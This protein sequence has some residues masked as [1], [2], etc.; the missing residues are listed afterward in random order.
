MFNFFCRLETFL[1][2]SISFLKFGINRPWVSHS[3]IV[4]G[5]STPFA[6]NIFSDSNDTPFTMFFSLFLNCPRS[7]HPVY[8]FN[9]PKADQFVQY[10]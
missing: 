5:N 9:V 7:A 4:D 10:F 3:T 1:V 2:C 8:L 6:V